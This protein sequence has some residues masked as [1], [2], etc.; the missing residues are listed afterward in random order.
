MQY[1][2][3]NG[4]CETFRVRGEFAFA[5]NRAKPWYPLGAEGAGVVVALGEDV[6]SLQVCGG[7][8]HPGSSMMHGPA[9]TWLPPFPMHA[10]APTHPTLTL[11]MSYLTQVTH[12]LANHQSALRCDLVTRQPPQVG[13]P[14]ACNGAS[15]FTE[16]AVAKAAM[17]TPVAAASAEAVALVLSGVTACAALEVWGVGLR[18]GTWAS[19]TAAMRDDMGT[20]S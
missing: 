4:G 18:E 14:V 11:Y 17:C 2:G 7:L 3:I 9:H 8:C 10:R 1:A 6:S 5:G 19:L 13:Q 15:A 20:R 16:Y 12:K